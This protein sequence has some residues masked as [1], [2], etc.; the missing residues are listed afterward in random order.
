MAWVWGLLWFAAALPGAAGALILNSS[1]PNVSL[2]ATLFAIT[3]VLLVLPL[4]LP[5]QALRFYQRGV[6]EHRPLIGV[7]SLPYEEIEHMMWRAARQQVGVSVTVEFLA[8]GRRIGFTGLKD[9]G[10][11]SQQR[12]EEL[13]DRV[14]P[15]VAARVR[16]Q[17][18]A[19]QPFAWGPRRR[20]RVRL[21]GDG[22]VY[23]RAQFLGPLETGLFGDEQL[24]PWTTPLRFAIREGAI[25]VFPA[26]EDKALFSFPCGSPDFYP[27]LLV[28]SSMGQVQE[29][30]SRDRWAVVENLY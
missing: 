20:A 11:R 19:N 4:S 18:Q 28:F 29:I 15:Y 22:I 13:R 9:T 6:V 26:K 14:A 27:G 3:G 1:A 17:I 10:G 8:A 25:A 2:A 30:G 7:R 16:R 12:L 24:L 23:R 5:S 21:Q